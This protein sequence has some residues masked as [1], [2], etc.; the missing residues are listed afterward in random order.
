MFVWLGLKLTANN[1]V[2]ANLMSLLPKSTMDL[3]VTDTVTKVQKRFERQLIWLIGGADK[4]TTQAA[5]LNV[6]SKMQET[7]QF[8]TLSLIHTHSMEKHVGSFYRKFRFSLLSDDMR[9]AIIG[10][11]FDSI[12]RSI[13]SRYYSLQSSFTST[14]IEKDPLLLLPQFLEE[15][16]AQINER[17]ELEDGFLT[18]KANN[19]TFILMT[20][21]LLGSPFSFDVQ[22]KLM[23]LLAQLKVTLP[24]ENSGVT[25]HV[26]GVLPHAAAGTRHAIDEM[27]YIGLGSILGII[28]IFYAVFRSI[29]PLGLTLLSI[30]IG[31]GGGLAAC[32]LMFGEV[33]LLTL[34]FGSSLVGISV[35]Y[36]LHFFCGR[37]R[38]GENWDSDDAL[39]HI[40]TGI[41]LGLITSIIGFGGLFVAPFKGMRELAVFSSVGLFFAFCCVLTWY[42]LLSRT[43]RKPALPGLLKVARGYENLWS[44]RGGRR[45][46]ILAFMLFVLLSFGCSKLVVQDDVR[47]LHT[48]DSKVLAEEFQTRDIIGR[49]LSSQFF[50]VEGTDPDDYLVQEEVLT[51]ALQK[52][53]QN[54][55]LDGYLAISDF[56]PSS[57]RQ[58][59]NRRLVRQLIEGKDSVLATL[60]SKIALP[61]E[62]QLA[63]IKAYSMSEEGPIIGMEQWLESPL[64]EPY[65]HLWIGESSRGVI[66]VVGLKGVFDLNALHDIASRDEGIHFRDPAGEVSELFAKYRHQTVWL[67]LISYFIVMLI[68]IFRYGA[69]SGMAVLFAPVIAAFS[70]LGVL[71]LLGEPISL[72]NIMALLLVLGIGVDYS[73]FFKESGAAHP[74]TFVAIAL[75]S[76]TTLLAFG[77]LAFSSTEGIHGFG[78][79][80][81]I[82]ILVAFLLSP[83]AGISDKTH[84]EP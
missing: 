43:L 75:S 42:P 19:K 28:V 61:I 72:F 20:G 76:I 22:E 25:M 48:P 35:D 24:I 55:R 44:Q 74:S 40:R 69:R 49:N 79:T 17:V 65:R 57:K 58:M 59:E 33:H 4:Q 7:G 30:V 15:R 8:E 47:L 73:L 41:T 62:T 71:G 14:V 64:S 5:A 36:S 29:R 56:I 12:E 38:Y 66:G 13:L 3:V 54:G 10:D 52:L 16:A 77:L 26:A 6:F 51:N 46:K 45:T 50:I 82:G 83:M 9:E 34:V 37:Y 11:K 78:L 21:A 60:A 67:T 2:N 31:I 23:P 32:I 81:T 1:V 39:R 70:S 84:A 68:I 53:T 63:Y 27:S 18:I 80:I